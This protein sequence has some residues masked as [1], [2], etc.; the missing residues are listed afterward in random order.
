M[1]PVYVGSIPVHALIDTGAS[2]SL[3][4]GKLYQKL[5][6]RRG[7]KGTTPIHKFE[8][9]KLLAADSSPM[10]VTAS[11]ETEV[12][13]NGLVIPFDFLVIDSLSYDCLL[14]MDFLKFTNA[15]IDI[16]SSTLS[17]FDGMTSVPMTR[18]GNEATVQTIAN[19]SIPALSEALIPVITKRTV[20]FG[21]Y[22]I[23]GSIHA[24]CRSLMIA[25][26]L[27]NPKIRTMI[28]R[29][30]NPT[31][32]I[33]R[34][35]SGT[36]IGEMSPV[37][38][39]SVKTDETSLK[40][41]DLKPLPSV[42]EMR[43]VL[44][45]KNISLDN[46]VF[47]GADLENLI[48]ML[49]KN[50]DIMANSLKELPGCDVLLYRIDTGNHPPFKQRSY[51]YSPA[52]KAEISRQ[53]Q[54]MLEADIIEP[55]DSPW[56]SPV[57][58][59]TKKDQSKRFVIDYRRVN[60]ATTLT[61]WPMPTLDDFLDT[62]G[63][64]QGQGQVKGR[65]LYFSAL[66]LKSGYFQCMLDPETADRTAFAT[67]E[68]NFVYKRLSFGL[69]GACGFFQMVMQKVLRTMS[70]SS[71]LIYLDDCLILAH[72]PTEMIN[73]LQEVFDCFRKARL[74][75]HP[76]KCQ[77][78][79]RRVRFLGHV[80]DQQGISVD[81]SKISIVKNYPVPNTPKKV[82]SF[83][84]LCSYYRR[85]VKDFSSIASPLRLLLKQNTKF[86]WTQ[87]C[88]E[89]FEEL[90]QKLITAPILSLPDFSRPFYLT[91]DASNFA[92]S[93]ILSQKDSEGR[94]RVIC[95]AGR[96]LRGAEIRYTVT[97]KECLA[98][99]TGVR[100]FHSYL[101]G[102]EFF[103]VTDHK[104]NTY[105]NT[106]KLSGNSRLARWALALEPY[107]FTVIYKKGAT[108]SS[109][110]AL[111]R[112]ENLP[113][114]I[115]GEMQV[116][117][118]ETVNG[119]S[120]NTRV[121]IDFDFADSVTENYDVIA[122]A[123]D[124]DS[125]FIP[126][127]EELKKAQ[128]TCA[129][130]A[131]IYAYLLDRS[132]PRD[133]QQARRITAEAPNYVLENQ[134]LFHL[135]TPRTK[136][137]HRVYSVVKQLCIPT[138]YR[139]R[140]AKELHDRC[141]HIGFDRLYATFRMR[142]F[143]P[144]S[145]N[146]LK[147]YVHSCLS[148]QQN[149]RQFHANKNV[150]LNLGVPLPL[151]RYFIDHHGPLIESNSFKYILIIIDSTSMW[152]ELIPVRSCDAE[153]TFDALYD[154]ICCRFGVPHSIVTDNGAAF[155]SRLAQL[156]CEKFRIS[157][158]LTSTYHAQS[159]SFAEQ[160]A[161]TLHTSLRGMCEKHSDW[162][163]HLQSVAYSL[164]CSPTSSS[165]LSPFEVIFGRRMITPIEWNFTPDP[166]TVE[167]AE[168]YARC[169]RPKLQVLAELAMENAHQSAI[170]HAAIKNKNATLPTF[171][172][173]DKVL[174]SNTVTKQ[175]EC[176]KL[177]KRFNGPYQ[178]EEIR[179][180]FNYI[181]KHVDSGE[182][183]RRPVHADRLRPFFERTTATNFTA[184]THVCTYEGKTK[185]RE[186]GVKIIVGDICKSG[187][188]V[189][190]SPT[191]ARFKNKRDVA[192]AIQRATGDE[193]RK[194]CQQFLQQHSRL[195][196]ATPFFTTAGSLQP[197]V[198]F[199]CHIVPP[200]LQNNKPDFD[201]LRAE[202]ELC[203]TYYRCL[204]AIDSK[205]DIESVAI[206]LIVCTDVLE[207]WSASHNAIKALVK[208]DQE[209]YQTPGNL[210]RVVFVNLSLATVDVLTTV[211]RKILESPVVS[212][213]QTASQQQSQETTDNT[214]TANDEDWYPISEIL[215]GQKRKGKMYY[216]VRW[217]TGETQWLRA[218]DIS[219]YAIEQFK[220]SRPARK[221]KRQS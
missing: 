176:S 135:Y 150:V 174:L 17:I 58:L 115:D 166:P 18:H 21:D 171:K 91:T 191:D 152:V 132:L 9:R 155:T 209:T 80:L 62:I 54:E 165:L 48:T 93:F 133:E 181:L 110:D 70:P 122:T 68:G 7:F 74:R 94:E 126:S 29:V 33:I 212:L 140:I 204:K 156:F 199:I 55:S 23:E 13:I 69:S 195:K 219:D 178:I 57:I 213:D 3:L 100:H 46:T 119:N 43:R 200:R 47:E 149:K 99:V 35:R 188:D 112:I 123:D 196:D 159:N 118:N 84:G 66:D 81:E 107:R 180:G 60:Q 4:S 73:R 202:N 158:R 61:S 148:C 205:P 72:S 92:I 79:L 59:V 8:N 104:A 113:T 106:M 163:R 6:S 67:H 96:G 37:T 121:S 215:K 153:T 134:T 19:I 10:R 186:L 138:D 151:T 146:W 208:F 128:A 49:Y 207:P 87:K 88:Q 141:A 31:E 34:L 11:V 83:I 210:K 216:L 85:F 125:L 189:L 22:M 51:R 206:P 131:D 78:G 90:K 24:P 164:R 197:C 97:E 129:D 198:K 187:C 127:L 89:A 108:L 98:I 65:G 214:T 117:E 5:L 143:F 193:T 63:Q 201:A 82:K 137:I 25:R 157:H 28:C 185:N 75:I 169:I 42:A 20:P 147:N 111:S 44:E 41:T 12:K 145:Y 162:S 109:A 15:V 76:A 182:I 71:V 139:E 144:G 116:K 64:G 168:E 220:A 136:K 184:A 120:Q 192:L 27:V 154:H 1:I 172:Q 103:I 167:S 160:A 2:C 105:L 14:G 124:L 101:G 142:F 217:E 26:T 38:V 211:C 52:D 16:R 95:Y 32:K 30:M 183:L 102:S 130:F 45:E 194:Q 170:R 203:N 179:N 53:T 161:S 56:S 173:G 190:I 77:F 177:I 36:T 50:T 114:T 218:K 86:V 40:T 39:N 221:R 175:N